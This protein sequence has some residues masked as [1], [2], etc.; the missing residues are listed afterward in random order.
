VQVVDLYG[1]YQKIN[2]PYPSQELDR[3]YFFLFTNT[4][5][6]VTAAS[7]WLGGAGA[8]CQCVGFTNACSP[9][10]HA[11][12]IHASSSVKMFFAQ[13]AA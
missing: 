9:S 2:V 12:T 5:P 6:Y 11:A 3:V 7:V 13:C 4:M 8:G 1:V 10:P